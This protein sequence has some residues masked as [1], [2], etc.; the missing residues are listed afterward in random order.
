M[1]RKMNGLDLHTSTEIKH[2]SIPESLSIGPRGVAELFEDHL[3]E[4]ATLATRQP[5]DRKKALD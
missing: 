5:V 2:M 1:S 4:F 3:L